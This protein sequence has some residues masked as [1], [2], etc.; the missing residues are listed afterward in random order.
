[1]WVVGFMPTLDKAS[2]QQRRLAREHSHHRC[3][4]LAQSQHPHPSTPGRRYQLSLAALLLA[5]RLADW[6]PCGSHLLDREPRTSDSWESNMLAACNRAELQEADPCR[7]P[8]LEATCTVPFRVH[9]RAESSAR[10]IKF[11]AVQVT[12]PKP[13]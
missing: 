4:S 13:R 1:M 11:G 3:T 5:N 2:V 9:S 7:R 8:P 12:I 6:R 10:K